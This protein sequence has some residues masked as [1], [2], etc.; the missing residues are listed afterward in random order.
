ME[1]PLGILFSADQWGAATAR[2]LSTKGVRNYR[3]IADNA[4]S[5]EKG[6]TLAWLRS[7]GQASTAAA[8]QRTAASP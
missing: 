4:D 7:K 3:E 8:H 2:S 6:A 1:C 5:K